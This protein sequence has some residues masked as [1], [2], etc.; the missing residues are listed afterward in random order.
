MCITDL[1]RSGLS[2]F[3][4]SAANR[5]K[6]T[7]ARENRRVHRSLPADACTALVRTMWQQRHALLLIS[8]SA[9]H[10]SNAIDSLRFND[11]KAKTAGSPWRSQMVDGKAYFGIFPDEDP[12][13]PRPLLHSP[14]LIASLRALE[15]ELRPYIAALS[16]LNVSAD[17]PPA[18]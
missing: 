17:E 5:R 1:I 6:P 9:L 18:S 7:P 16:S 15:K 10:E 2:D 8:G 13:R 3:S 14:Q 12:A 11:S 4:N